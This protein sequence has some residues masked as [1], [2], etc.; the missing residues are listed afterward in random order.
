MFLFGEYN[1]FALSHRYMSS[2]SLQ[3]KDENLR[4]RPSSNSSLLQQSYHTVPLHMSHHGS[5]S[6][7]MGPCPWQ[8]GSTPPPEIHRP[9]AQWPD[10]RSPWHHAPLRGSAP[11]TPLLRVRIPQLDAD[12]LAGRFQAHSTGQQNALHIIMQARD[13]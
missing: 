7:H 8:A 6:E 4:H 10:G 12:L 1:N 5:G 3:A 9:L 2:T 11:T 13:L